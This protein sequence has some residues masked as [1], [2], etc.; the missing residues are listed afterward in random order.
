VHGWTRNLMRNLSENSFHSFL[1]I[2]PLLIDE[3]LRNLAQKT[4]TDFSTKKSLFAPSITW[5]YCNMSDLLITCIVN[6]KLNLRTLVHTKKFREHLEV[7]E[8]YLV[9]AKNEISEGLQS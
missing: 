7:F 5:L 3:S 4:H 2:F 9:R 1:L 8:N 6:N